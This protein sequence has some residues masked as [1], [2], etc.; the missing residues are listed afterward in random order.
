MVLR[1]AVLQDSS[2]LRLVSQI[3]SCAHRVDVIKTRIQTGTRKS[4][5]KSLN[6]GAP[7]PPLAAGF[8][9]APQN[10]RTESVL[11]ALRQVYDHEGL[12]GLFRGMGPRSGWCGCQSGVMFLGYEFFLRVLEKWQAGV[13][14]IGR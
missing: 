6:I 11:N 1:P 8:S 4:P 3:A 10:I 13:E 14:T 2:R 9:S 5:S 12:R 7:Q